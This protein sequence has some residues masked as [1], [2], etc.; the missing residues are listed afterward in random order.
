MSEA[1]EQRR[2]RVSG[3]VQGVFFRV[4][5]REQAS[6]LGLRGWVRN[7]ADG[8][9]EAVASGDSEAMSA[10]AEWLAVG[11][12]RAAV[13]NVASEVVELPLPRAFEIR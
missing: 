8:S 7:C 11:P 9:V 4:S 10:F 3:R 5:A 13:A 1:A 6:A 12:P 2:F